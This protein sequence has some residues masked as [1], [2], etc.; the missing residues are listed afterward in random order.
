MKFFGSIRDPSAWIASLRFE[1]LEVCPGILWRTSCPMWSLLDPVLYKLPPER[2][3]SNLM[4]YHLPLEGP[5]RQNDGGPT[6]PGG[7]D[8]HDL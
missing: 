5:C 3:S 7:G 1:I 4:Y 8:D 6:L 2:P